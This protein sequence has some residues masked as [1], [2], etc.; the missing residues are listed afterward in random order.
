MNECLNRL[1]LEHRFPSLL[2][3]FRSLPPRTEML[4]IEMIFV[5]V[6]QMI[7]LLF[8]KLAASHLICAV[9]K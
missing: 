1:M 7:S 4:N 6:P 3:L 9:L 8:A 5:F 2:G